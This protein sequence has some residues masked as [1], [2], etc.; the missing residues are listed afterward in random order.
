MS[1][2]A[3]A[4]TAASVEVES[5]DDA[6]ANKKQLSELRSIW[7][8]E[9]V[10]KTGD[11]ESGEEW[12]CHWC[13]HKFKGWN[14]AKALTHVVR[15]GGKNDLRDCTGKILPDYATRYKALYDAKMNKKRARVEADRGVIQANTTEAAALLQKKKKRSPDAALPH[16]RGGPLMRLT[17]DMFRQHSDLYL[18]QAAILER[19]AT[20]PTDPVSW[21]LEE[22]SPESIQDCL[23]RENTAALAVKSYQS[24]LQVQQ[25]V[26]YLERLM[27]RNGIGKKQ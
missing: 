23:L 14:A 25:R 17:A 4:A 13:S 26:D 18:K 19:I 5:E 9:Y 1:D 12:E 11:K 3:G 10:S 22:P 6:D 27:I 8:C 16:E 15:K 24:M 2:I 21:Q 20:N 7:D